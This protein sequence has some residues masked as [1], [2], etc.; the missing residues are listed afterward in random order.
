MKE[1]ETS[2]ELTKKKLKVFVDNGRAQLLEAFQTL[3]NPGAPEAKKEVSLH[4]ACAMAM[5]TL[6]EPDVLLTYARHMDASQECVS[7][8]HSGA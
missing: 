1:P 7:S 5:G 6:K 8:P 2:T 3:S 4:S